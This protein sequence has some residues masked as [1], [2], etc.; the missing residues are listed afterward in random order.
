MADMSDKTITGHNAAHL[1]EDIL[2]RRDRESSTGSSQDP[3]ADITEC[4][5]KFL[6][7]KQEW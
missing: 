7:E 1:P 3:T 6:T 5:E 2:N 4:W